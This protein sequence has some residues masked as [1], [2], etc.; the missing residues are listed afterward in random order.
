[1][2][3]RSS[4]VSKLRA[5]FD[6]GENTLLAFI[7]FIL[8]VNMNI[9]II[10]AD[11]DMTECAPGDLDPHAVASVLRAFLRERKCISSWEH[12]ITDQAIPFCSP[13]TYTH[14]YTDTLL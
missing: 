14:A 3:G 8:I 4:H 5:E 7:M 9:G 10:G 2:S 12:F 13:G 11:F 6:T 1:M